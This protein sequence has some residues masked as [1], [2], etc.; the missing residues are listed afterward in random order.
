MKKTFYSYSFGCRVNQ[1][2]KEALDRELSRL[3]FTFNQSKP[4]VYIINSC[5]VTH[6]AEREAKQLI[7][8][9]KRDLPG[10]KIVVTGCAATNWIK[11]GQKV[12]EVDYI[13]DNKNKE[14]LASIIYKQTAD[15][16]SESNQTLAGVLPAAHTNKYT[17]S[18]RM[19][20]KI[21]DGCQRF[22]TFCIV[23][24]L[25]GLPVSTS[26]ESIVSTING[27]PYLKE[28]ILVAIN[29]EAYGYDTKE[30]FINLVNQVLEKTTTPRISFGSVHPWTVKDDFIAWY[31]KM[32]GQ[33]RV[34][35]FFHIPL[36][37][38]SDKILNL[39]KRGYTRQEYI[40]KLN[41]LSSINPFCFIG[42]DIIAGFLEET[43]VDFQDTYSFLESTPIS[44]FHVFRY[45]KRNH[46]AAFYMGKRLQEPAASMKAAR[47]KALIALGQKKYTNFLEKH[48]GATFQALFLEKTSEGFQHVLLSNQIPA[49]IKT[50]KNYT[51][52]IRRVTINSYKKDNLFGTIT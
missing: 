17:S 43:D 37:S 19:F 27:R 28:A 9:V 36:Q 35:D 31:K 22:C 6:K 2:E 7:Y 12:D 34:V 44:K 41:A 39:M 32:S 29:T 3:G 20:I 50:E 16:K 30:T 26:I 18:G 40:E 47:S 21:Q 15:E 49:M 33:G 48:V 4:D 11:Q 23:P 25:R 38:G 13:I 51:G 1:A 14:Y 45:S 5:S 42:T 8:K 46:T 52:Q 10:T 24:Y